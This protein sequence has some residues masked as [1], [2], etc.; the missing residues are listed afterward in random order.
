METWIALLV[1]GSALMHASW[2]AVV[3]SGADRLLTLAAV[4]LPNMA[5]AAAALL[6]FAWPRP[7]SLPYL[8]VSTAAVTAYY[9]CLLRA[10]RLSDFNLAYP[11]ARGTAPVLILLLAALVGGETI[12]PG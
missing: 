5:L 3:K 9:F 12:R 7:E 8:L 4:K 1:L 10:Y 2:N 11:V 6:V